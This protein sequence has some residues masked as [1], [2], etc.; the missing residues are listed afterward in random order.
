MSD[1]E[2][3]GAAMF[4]PD[5]SLLQEGW[6]YRFV[7]SGQR[8][9]EAQELYAELGFDVR[10]ESI[11][12]EAFPEGCEECQLILMLKFKAIYTRQPL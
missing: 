11:P 4:R 9:Q 12:P 5:A 6:K 10:S 7:A 2:Q 1:V 3:L 8:L